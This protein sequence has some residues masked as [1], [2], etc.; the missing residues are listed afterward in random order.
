MLNIQLKTSNGVER[1]CTFITVC[2]RESLNFASTYSEHP[3]VDISFGDRFDFGFYLFDKLRHSDSIR[4]HYRTGLLGGHFVG[5]RLFIRRRVSRISLLVDQPG[6]A[7][8]HH[9]AHSGDG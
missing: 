9:A 2:P 7:R 1:V 5:R 3:F 8:G 6:E 4:S